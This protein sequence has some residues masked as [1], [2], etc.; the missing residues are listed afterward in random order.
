MTGWV[1]IWV[2]GVVA[3][4]GALA[5]HR[6]HWAAGWWYSQA[7]AAHVIE[8]TERDLEPIPAPEYG[9]MIWDEERAL[10]PAGWLRGLDG[11]LSSTTTTGLP[12]ADAEDYDPGLDEPWSWREQT[13]A[14]LAPEALGQE[15]MPD[16]PAPSTEMQMLRVPTAAHV[17]PGPGDLSSL[18]PGPGQTPALVPDNKGGHDGKGEGR[19]FHGLNHADE[20]LADTGDIMDAHLLAD[21]Q[22]F[23]RA[24]DADAVAHVARLR[25]DLQAALA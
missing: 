13:A 16:E 22:A 15:V 8:Q 23:M 7:H 1:V 6:Y 19:A 17:S 10:S 3:V 4:L 11:V 5:N 24:K 14:D 20:R 18:A 2:L 12:P 9:S 21:V 25:A